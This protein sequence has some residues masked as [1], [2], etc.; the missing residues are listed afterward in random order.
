MI[1]KHYLIEGLIQGVGF[2]PFIYKIATKLELHGYVKNTPKGVELELQGCIESIR[3]FEKELHSSLP[4][5][6][7]IDNM[8]SSFMAIDRNNK[9][10]EIL[11]SEHNAQKTAFVMPDITVCEDCLEDIKSGRFQDYFA[12][13]CTNCGPRYSILKTLPYDRAN[14]SMAEF[15]MCDE[16]AKD[17]EDPTSR[18]Y[19]A[20]PLS[21][22]KCG[23]QLNNS[24]ED[25][26]DAIKSGKIV[27][28]KGI[29]GFHIVCDASNDDALKRLR[30]FKNRPSKPFALMCRSVDDVLKLAHLS[31][32]EKDVLDS[33]ERPIVLL[34]KKENSILS[35]LIAPNIDRVGCMLPY[36]PL[37]H[38]LFEHLDAP[39]V[40]TSANLSGEPI[41][42]SKED[43]ETKLPF[44]EFILDF[45]REIIN[46]VDDSVVQIV[47]DKL[48][49]LRLSRGFAPKALK[50][51]FAV[52]K[53]I[54]SVGA[55]QKSS[56]CICYDDNLILSP[57]I[58]D[59][60]SL[61]SME[62]FQRTIET[63]KRFY[64]FDAELIVHDA[65]PEY[66]STKWAKEQPRELFE[67]AHHIAHIYAAK[68][69]YG[70]E[71]DYLGFS[72]DGT[73]LG[74]DNTLWG[75]EVFVGDARKYH[76]KPIKLLGGQNAIKEP[77]RVALSMLFER[78]T[79][80][81]LLKL[82]IA[83]V[84]EFTSNEI[85]LL[86][87]SYTKGINAPLSSSVGRVFDAVASLSDLLHIQ[88]YEG[89]AGLICEKNYDAQIKSFFEFSIVDGVIDIEFD[90]FDKELVSKFINTLVEIIIFIS[91][92]EALEVILSGG[93]F[94]NR[95]LLELCA[96]RLR[97]EKIDFFVQ[98]Q[99]PVNDGSISL[100]QLYYYILNY[101]LIK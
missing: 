40:A 83:C 18:R 53:K 66:E 36:T 24:I 56:I 91:K 43:I 69:E 87:Q 5:L 63:F 32:K 21:C 30:M 75:G 72:F 80:D 92:K 70:L 67:V 52:D 61:M 86:H 99:T 81:E 50:L 16:C 25:T 77:K 90:L 79:L 85:K 33:R 17:Y 97:E 6:A 19:H 44:V 60:D 35:D 62:Y 58:G 13:N 39:I 93:V 12:T 74:S 54:L 100:G 64:D 10:F 55:N 1:R 65:H 23:P 26:A 41:I 47:D 4:P 31:K 89:E 96:S 101:N 59:L 9:S 2:R 84:K 95:T 22:S 78:Y 34:E 38:I 15:K 27:A 14:T 7:R 46:A 3:E 71:G 29:G 68:A 20:Q 88:T 76:F 11:Q 48:Q 45:N 28:I 51:P 42:T 98:S 82:D 94:Q 8:T 73:G 37:H 57:H 49:V